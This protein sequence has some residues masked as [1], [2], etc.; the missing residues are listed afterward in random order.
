[1]TEYIGIRLVSD[2]FNM[3]KFYKD[4]EKFLIITRGLILL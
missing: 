2:G 4:G 1:M 3:I